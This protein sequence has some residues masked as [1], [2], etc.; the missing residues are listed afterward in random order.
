MAQK[1]LS[2]LRYPSLSPDGKTIIF[3][4]K[5]NLYKVSATGGRATRLTF[6]GMHN[7]M[8]VWSHDGRQIA[9]ASSRSGNFDIFVMPAAGGNARRITFHSADEFPYD[10]SSDDSSVLFG[11]V[12]MDAAG[13]RQFPS[14]GMPEL[15]RVPVNGGKVEQVLTTPAEDARVS[16]NGRYIIYHDKKGRENAWRKHQVSSIARDIW[17]FDSQHNTHKK[18]TAFKGENRNPVFAGQDQEVYYL[19]EE[20]G[21]FN[22]YKLLLDHPGHSQQVTFFKKHP[23]RFLTIARKGALCFSY[24]GE[25]YVKKPGAAPRKVRI[26]MDATPSGDD[27]Q[28]VPLKEDLKNQVVSPTG[29][30][31]AFIFRGEVFTCAIPG[32]PV[33]R[34]TYTPGEEADLSF[35]S[36]GK[37]LLY[38]SER[39]NGWQI[40]QTDITTAQPK[41]T[42][43][44]KNDQEN[45]QPR[46]SPDGREVAFIANRTALKIYNT[47]SRQTRTILTPAQLYSRTDHDQYFRWSPDGKWLLV[48]YN[49]EGMGNQDIGI[50]AADGQGKLVNLTE[51]GYSDERPQWAMNGK[52]MI[53]SSDRTGLRSYSNSGS[54][55]HDIYAM[56]FADTTAPAQEPGGISLS[57]KLMIDWEGL[58]DRT[59]KLTTSP[60]MLADALIS[61]N[62]RTLYHLTRSGKA[63]SLWITDLPTKTTRS[64]LTLNAEDCTLQWDTAQQNIFLLADNRIIRANLQ[65]KQLDSTIIKGEMRIDLAAE[66]RSMFLHVWRRTKTAFYT[67]GYHGADWDGYKQDYEQYLPHISN[68]YEFAEMLSELLGELNVSHSGATFNNRMPG[69]DVTASLGAFYNTSYKGAGMQIEEIIRNGPLDKGGFQ[70]KPGMIIEA[71]DGEKITADKDLAQY[72]NHKAGKKTILT[73]ADGGKLRDIT[74]QPVSPDEEN[75]LLYRRWVRRNQDEV[76]R[77]SKGQLG[78]IHLYRMNDDAYRNAY[79]EMM[80]KYAGRKGMIV[81]TRFNRGG[82]LASDLD[83]FL[84]GKEILRNTTDERIVG[85][86]PGFRW[87]K[88][89]IVLANE[90]NYS[91]GHCFVYG[92]QYLHLGKLVGMPVPGSCTFMTGESLQD[93]SLHWS[94]PSL[95]VKSMEGYYLENHQTEPDITVMN[96]FEKVSR[97]E[98]QQLEEAAKQLME[99]R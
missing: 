20:S 97:G 1:P 22:V 28:L 10:F 29:K 84:S 44:I 42:T 54:R 58:R 67:K 72:L 53:W 12:R 8:P 5:S 99:G 46:F 16:N 26:S 94:V 55:Q 40:C 52:A 71:V 11:S 69:R 62:G 6:A 68:N 24:N 48:Q 74:V 17:L 7:F 92:Y 98:D 87:T 86:E 82:D 95:G 39:D 63:Y 45:Y 23:V 33:K 80:G 25:L 81:D 57:P 4:Y 49:Q 88:S 18:I 30:M 3:T 70:L 89:S 79:G 36:D 50:I 43:L 15:Y 13:N 90:A 31:A 78:Y 37:F 75:E 65:G 32:G 14:D 35:S 9:F 64:P 41:E 93:N 2:W 73:V 60:A 85:I 27:E 38:A 59:A 21:S 96:E 91:D 61:E 83:M 56:F 77:L 34:I 76:E 47:V 19:S 66:R 51:S